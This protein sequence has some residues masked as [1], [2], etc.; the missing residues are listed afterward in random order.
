MIMEK[1]TLVAKLSNMKMNRSQIKPSKCVPLKHLGNHGRETLRQIKTRQHA[2]GS[3][4][5]K[6]SRVDIYMEP[7]VTKS[8]YK[9]HL[10][11]RCP[12]VPVD[13]KGL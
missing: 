12:C 8:T 9:W 1:F 11:N 3:S 6:L 7:F 13:R 2:E 5:A 10:S 4:P